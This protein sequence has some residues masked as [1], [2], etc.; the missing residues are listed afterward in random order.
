MRPPEG[1]SDGDTPPNSL[2]TM[3]ERMDHSKRY[4]AAQVH[5]SARKAEGWGARETK[6]GLLSSNN[7]KTRRGR[8][9][10][11]KMAESS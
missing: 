1:V 2:I 3:S 10:H 4:C 6:L 9:C 11:Q 8:D 7:A 5:K